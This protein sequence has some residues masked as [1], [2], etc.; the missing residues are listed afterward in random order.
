MGIKRAKDIIWGKTI[1]LTPPDGAMGRYPRLARLETGHHA[2]DL[3]LTYQTG[4]VGGDFMMY[5]S[6]PTMGQ[7]W[8]GPTLLN[9]ATPDWDFASAATSSSCRM[10]AF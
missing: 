3:L 2:G 6:H 4:N 5:R 10:A 7:T 8:S 1:T 9:R